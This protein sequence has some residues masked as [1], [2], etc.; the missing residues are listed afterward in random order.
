M[1]KLISKTG[2]WILGIIGL[3]LFIYIGLFAIS[4][5][6]AI[7]L[8]PFIV[9]E[10]LKDGGWL[11]LSLYYKIVIVFGGTIFTTIVLRELFNLLR[12]LKSKLM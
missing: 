12:W 4:V 7:I 5:I 2:S 11:E 9:F 10:I 6:P 8:S 3:V 1:N